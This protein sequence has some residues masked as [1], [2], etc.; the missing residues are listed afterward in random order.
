MNTRQTIRNKDDLR[1]DSGDD[2]DLNECRRLGR[3]DVLQTFE[4]YQQMELAR[5]RARER[6]SEIVRG[7]YASRGEPG[8][9]LH[10]YQGCATGPDPRGG[11]TGVR[12]TPYAGQVPRHSVTGFN[13]LVERGRVLRL[14][15]GPSVSP[16]VCKSPSSD[17]G[18]SVPTCPTRPIIQGRRRLNVPHTTTNQHGTPLDGPARYETGR[19]AGK[20]P[21]PSLT[22]AATDDTAKTLKPYLA[23]I[24]NTLKGLGPCLAQINVLAG[25]C[26]P[27]TRP[28]RTSRTSKIMSSASG[29]TP[30]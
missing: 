29:A 22:P 21:S 26:G 8:P 23:S 11:D 14:L 20:S 9:K 17:S 16:P 7:R 3:G 15:Q 4:E 13:H 25:P 2:L 19:G 10:R 24:D 6:E 5:E 12:G 28:T 18:H 27:N 1:M 30:A